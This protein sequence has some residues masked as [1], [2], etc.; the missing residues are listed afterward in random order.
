MTGTEKNDVRA[1]RAMTYWLVLVSALSMLLAGPASAVT[2]SGLY[3]V[4]VAVNGTSQNDLRTGYAEGLRRVMV[5]V[6]GTRDVLQLEGADEVLKDA[7]SLLLAYQV[8]RE[9][10]ESRLQMSF[11]AVGV[12]RAL[13]S[14]NAPVWGAN[15]PLTLVWAAIED[16]GERKLL[17]A[18]TDESEA[19]GSAV[20][21][22][23]RAFLAAAEERGLPIAF[24]PEGA[25]SDRSLLSDLWGQFVGRIKEA[26]SDLSHDALALM[27]VSRSG[28]QW[29][30]GWVFDGMSMDASEQSVTAADPEELARRVVGRWADAY[31]SR[32][33][34]AAGE[35]GESPRVD[36]VLEGV[37]TLADYGNVGKALTSF[38]PVVSVGASRVR[39]E[40][41]TVQVTFTGELDQLKE[42]IA[43]DPRFVVMEGRPEET[44]SAPRAAAASTGAEPQGAEEPGEPGDQY[45]GDAMF[46]YQPLDDG[47]EQDAEQAFESLYQVLYY[48]WQPAPVVRG[49]GS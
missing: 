10:G 5:R 26:S 35:V 1:F 31:A 49:G 20:A 4:E 47:D 16:R 46:V 8:R 12:N 27:R 19:G 38:T 11:G 18:A 29:R 43:L 42:Y 33:A 3:N 15:R 2:V 9:A 40:R 24:P 7:E 30:A 6:S 44:V 17:T 14:I 23:R 36:I 41:M 39:S 13:A 28:G 32:Y 48:R 22:W 34:V 21:D 45:P 25:Q 37:N